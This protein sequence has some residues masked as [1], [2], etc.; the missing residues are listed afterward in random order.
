MEDAD[1]LITELDLGNSEMTVFRE[2]NCNCSQ[3][4]TDHINITHTIALVSFW[5]FIMCLQNDV[6]EIP[7]TLELKQQP[8]LKK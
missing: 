6:H 1:W 8:K 2:V 7:Q 4:I 3:P 5:Q